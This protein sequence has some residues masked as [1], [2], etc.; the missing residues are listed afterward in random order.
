MLVLIPARP[1][2]QVTH[3]PALR[4]TIAPET[5]DMPLVVDRRTGERLP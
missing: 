1:S 2:R 4:N 5:V 3:Q